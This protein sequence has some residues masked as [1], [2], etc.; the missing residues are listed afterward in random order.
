MTNTHRKTTNR[1][2]A[3]IAAVSAFGIGAAIAVPGL[4]AAQDAPAESPTASLE[5][6]AG[7]EGS[8][9]GAVGT[10]LAIDAGS[11]ALNLNLDAETPNPGSVELGSLGVS[12]N[13]GSGL[14][15]GDSGSGSSEEGDDAEGG[16]GSLDTGSLTGGSEDT[17]TGAAEGTADEAPAEDSGSLGSAEEAPAE[18]DADAPAEGDTEE[19]GSLS[20]SLAGLSSGAEDGADEGTDA[21]TDTGEVADD[22]TGDEATATTGSLG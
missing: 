18:D 12:P 21:D 3:R 20:G 13:T 6:I 17:E 2:A 9:E 10:D 19:T 15:D 14:V 1:T 16:S 8:L 5:G 7:E 11:L 22:A 4:A